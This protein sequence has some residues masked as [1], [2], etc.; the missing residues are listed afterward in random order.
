VALSAVAACKS[1]L[2]FQHDGGGSLHCDQRLT[3]LCISP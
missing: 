3:R 1:R 2:G